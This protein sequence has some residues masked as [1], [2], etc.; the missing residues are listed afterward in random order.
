MDVIGL[1]PCIV[2]G[3]TGIQGEDEPCERCQGTG[4]LPVLE[5]GKIISGIERRRWP[6]YYFDL[7]ARVVKEMVDGKRS[8]A[9]NARGTAINEGAWQ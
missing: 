3:L 9:V 8:A 4:L 5:G 6:R 7:H 1:T 2:C